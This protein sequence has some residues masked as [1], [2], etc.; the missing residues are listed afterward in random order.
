VQLSYL[1]YCF[2][3]YEEV[4]LLMPVLVDRIAR[5]RWKA[6]RK[7]MAHRELQGVGA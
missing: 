2:A 6:Y 7:S 4:E 5:G 1:G 3:A